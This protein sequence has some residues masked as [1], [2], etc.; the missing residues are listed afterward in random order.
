MT[1]LTSSQVSWWATHEYVT[2][3][4]EQ[5]NSWPLVGTPA[6]CALENCDPLKKASILD[7]AQHWA[8]RLETCQAQRCEAGRDV[9]GAA[10]WSAIARD[11]RNRAN[12]YA[13]RPWLKRVAS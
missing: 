5:V 6:W 13:A 3:W 12:F 10:N 9:A 7:A 2:P 4:L 1:L 11:V 8:L